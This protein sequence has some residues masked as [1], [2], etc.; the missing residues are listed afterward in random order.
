MSLDLP[1]AEKL[2]LPGAGVRLSGP[3]KAAIVVRL[4][5]QSGSI[6]ALSELPESVQTELAL[7]LARMA[8]VDQQTV[9]AVALEFAEAI[10][11]IGLSFPKGLE[12]ALGLLDGVISDGASNRVRQMTADRFHG[13]PWQRIESVENERLVPVLMGESVEVAAIILSKLKVSK[14]AELLGLLPGERARRITFAVSLTEAAAPDLVR[15]IGA[16]LVDQLDARPARAF[17]T[18]PVERV[19]A[20]LN[21]SP[22]SLRD[23]V[24]TGLD[25]EDAAFAEQ[26]RRAIFTFANIKDRVAARDVPRIQRDL[27]QADLVTAI[28][29]AQGADRETVEFLLANISQRL[30]DSLRAEAAE[31]GEVP[32]R[33]GEM[34]MMRIVNV[35]RELEAQGEI[36][37][38]ADEG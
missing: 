21:Y 13:D 19:G 38:V 8:P 16:V 17:A 25:S 14:A 26:V 30:A 33:D 36:F 28:A 10:E 1:M 6:P 7:Q 5:L 29:A 15:R 31:R 4:L 12:G 20:I 22:S 37:L 24:L 32:V 27:D 9:A 35:V 34:A 2:D 18:G 23:E 11:A 3:E